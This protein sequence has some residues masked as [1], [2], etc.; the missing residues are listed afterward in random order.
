M[1]SFGENKILTYICFKDTNCRICLAPGT[2]ILRHV[3]HF[4]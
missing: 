1:F 2:M 3:K 4:C